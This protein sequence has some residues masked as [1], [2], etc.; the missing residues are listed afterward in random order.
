MIPPFPPP[1]AILDPVCFCNR[2][3]PESA[4]QQ[5]TH[6]INQTTRL[7]HEYVRYQEPLS[8]YISQLQKSHENELR[9]AY[10]TLEDAHTQ[11]RALESKLR[12]LK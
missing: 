1:L 12:G 3:D 4:I 9:K 8:E 10:A 2:E 5:L 6:K 7:V 11:I